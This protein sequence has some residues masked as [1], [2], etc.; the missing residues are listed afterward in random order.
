MNAAGCSSVRPFDASPGA[1]G[2]AAEA[3]SCPFASILCFSQRRSG[4]ARG[5]RQSCGRS[6]T[7]RSHSD[8]GVPMRSRR[9]A[10]E[11]DR[12]RC[13]DHLSTTVKSRSVPAPGRLD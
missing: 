11:G 8:G 9:S 12:R 10:A 5:S 6:V 4:P 3:S 1:S 13:A 2:F 7:R